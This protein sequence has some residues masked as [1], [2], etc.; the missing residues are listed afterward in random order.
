MN[1]PCQSKEAVIWEMFVSGVTF[2]AI[3]T[4]GSKQEIDYAMS[5]DFLRGY[6]RPEDPGWKAC[7]SLKESFYLHASTCPVCKAEIEKR[8]EQ[9]YK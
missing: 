5:D 1:N 4:D 2:T 8:L 6:L 9:M 7:Q 3:F